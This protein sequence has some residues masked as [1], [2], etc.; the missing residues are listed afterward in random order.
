[1]QLR[2]KNTLSSLKTDNLNI[3]AKIC[4]FKFTVAWSEFLLRAIRV[5]KRLTNSVI[6]IFYFDNIH[7]TCY[8][9]ANQIINRVDKKL[10]IAMISN[11]MIII[12]V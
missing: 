5:L 6:N 4:K 11:K 7:S 8:E 10:I 2:I 12:T 9:T 3:Y 1:M